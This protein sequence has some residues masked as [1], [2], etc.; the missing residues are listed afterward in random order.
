MINIIK[1]ACDAQ[2]VRSLNV[3]LTRDDALSTR[4]PKRAIYIIVVK[5]A[6]NAGL[7][8]RLISLII[9]L[10]TNRPTALPPL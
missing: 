5:C 4:A 9:V 1:I 2:C 8:P 6:C 3:R 10:V 7:P